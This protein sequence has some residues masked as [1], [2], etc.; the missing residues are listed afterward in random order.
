MSPG[1]HPWYKLYIAFW[2]H[3]VQALED[4]GED[5]EAAAAAAV[6]SSAA[7]EDLHANLE[8]QLRASR[9]DVGRLQS[10]VKR[11][12]AAATAASRVTDAVTS[13]L[14]RDTSFLEE[15]SW[16]KSQLE[17]SETRCNLLQKQVTQLKAAAVPS[18]LAASNQ[19]AVVESAS[20]V[21]RDGSQTASSSGRTAGMGGTLPNGVLQGFFHKAALLSF[22]L[23]TASHLPPLNLA[24]KSK[25]RVPNGAAC[26]VCLCLWGLSGTSNKFEP[27]FFKMTKWYFTK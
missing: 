14:G 5:M 3:D 9:A 12:Q 16:L 2:C 20:P 25:R 1:I 22:K 27:A 18:A 26:F 4:Q 23:H 19:A 21:S 10:E 15:D 13:P 7:S 17:A 8:G 24:S 11:L 6:A